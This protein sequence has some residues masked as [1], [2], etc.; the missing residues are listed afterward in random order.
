MASRYLEPSTQGL[1][2]PTDAAKENGM[3][4]NPPR[5]AEHGGLT[6]PAKTAARNT[7]SI[8]KPGGGRKA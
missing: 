6:G 3:V 5:Y 7:L 1:R 4:I 8:S 2:R